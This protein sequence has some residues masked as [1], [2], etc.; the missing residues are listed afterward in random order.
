M[1]SVIIVCTIHVHVCN[2]YLYWKVI[3]K[4]CVKPIEGYKRK[5]NAAKKNQR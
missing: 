2:Y 1:M 3:Y 5:V 4:Y